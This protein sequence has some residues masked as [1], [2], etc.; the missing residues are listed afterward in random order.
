MTNRSSDVV[1]MVELSSV[2][3][4]AGNTTATLTITMTMYFPGTNNNE[5]SMYDKDRLPTICDNDSTTT[6]TRAF[7]PT[8]C[9]STPSLPAAGTC[10]LH[11]NGYYDIAESRTNFDRLQKVFSALRIIDRLAL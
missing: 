11:T 4:R 6:T 7:R 1:S 10:L 5:I 3:E 9:R 2:S 8:T